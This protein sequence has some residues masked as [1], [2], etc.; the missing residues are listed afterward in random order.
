MRSAKRLG[1]ALAALVACALAFSQW[2][3]P[4]IETARYAHET[5]GVSVSERQGAIDWEALRDSGVTFAYIEATEGGTANDS[6]FSRNWFAAEQAGMPRGAAHVFTLCHSG[7]AQAEN[8]IRVVP[9]D[10]SALPPTVHAYDMRP[11]RDREPVSDIAAE[12]AVFLEI[13]GKAFGKRPIVYAT[14]EFHDAH[15]HGKFADV[16]FW[17]RSLLFSP[18]YREDSWIFWHYH[19]RGRRSGIAGPVDLSVFRG[20]TQDLPAL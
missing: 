15:L 16:R 7:R 9:A 17:V 20:N 19:N 3:Y 6:R 12:I 5:H 11:C 4:L 8:F 1:T 14:R 10:P 18:R 2:G 13:I